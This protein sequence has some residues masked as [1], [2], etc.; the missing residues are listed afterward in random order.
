LGASISLSS[1]LEY[2]SRREDGNPTA[3]I[4]RSTVNPRETVG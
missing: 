4:G 3:R 2:A 1:L